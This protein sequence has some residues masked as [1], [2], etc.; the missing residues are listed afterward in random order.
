[1][2]W[3]DLSAR[4]ASAAPLL[5]TLLGGPAGGAVGGLIASVF[6]T[7]ATPDAVSQ[8]L[9]VSPD[10][11]VKLAEIEATHSTMLQQLT[12]Q[13]EQNRLAADTAAL[14][15]V[16]ASAQIEAKAD[17]WPTY[18][19]RPFVGFAFGASVWAG[20]LLVLGAFGAVVL[21]AKAAPAIMAQLPTVLGALAVL[22]GTTLPVLGVA[23]YFR[24]KMQAN[25]DLPTDNR[26]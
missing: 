9:T 21:D 23:S 18:S 10:A 3:K 14:Q 6:G 4:V 22:G 16:N 15:A 19:W 24:G 5:G 13:A 20:I 2:D 8:A 17:H 12:V 11:A 7:K 25:P 26:G 1:M